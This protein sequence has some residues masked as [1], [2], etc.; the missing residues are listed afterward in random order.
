MK[1][2]GKGNG[3]ANYEEMLNSLKL[4]VRVCGIIEST[5]ARIDNN[6]L[7]VLTHPFVPRPDISQEGRMQPTDTYSGC[8]ASMMAEQRNP[9]F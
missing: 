2:F 1:F 3:S 5:S 4:L 6:L 7:N 9:D 8:Q